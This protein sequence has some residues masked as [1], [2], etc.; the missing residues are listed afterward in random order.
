M[1]RVTWSASSR[2]SRNRRGRRRCRSRPDSNAGSGS[3]RTRVA[4]FRAFLARHPDA[5]QAIR[6]AAL[7]KL[8]SDQARQTSYRA[9][10]VPQRVA[11]VLLDQLGDHGQTSADGDLVIVAPLTEARI[12]DLIMLRPRV[13]RQTLAELAGKGLIA[14]RRTATGVLR[15][16]D[17]EGLR[18][19]SGI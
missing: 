15:V 14:R 12:A 9:G 11:R 10:P 3:A 2:R 17:V 6:R 8:T 1:A 18:Q 5:D 13:V 4:G 19:V 7:A 16:L